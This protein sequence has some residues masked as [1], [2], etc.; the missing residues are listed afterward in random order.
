MPIK[1]TKEGSTHHKDDACYKCGIC[2]SH[3]F[4]DRDR[5]QHVCQHP[6]LRLRYCHLG[7]WPGRVR[8][9]FT[10]G[11]IESSTGAHCLGAVRLIVA[12]RLCARA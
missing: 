10:A 5:M 3:F 4:T 8:P 1:D 2:K 9:G 12:L 7:W 6:D 11:A